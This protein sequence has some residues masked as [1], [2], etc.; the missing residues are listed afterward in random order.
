MAA[1]AGTI[2]VKAQLDTGQLQSG[3]KELQK[4]AQQASAAAGE[5]IENNITKS[6]N[7]VKTASKNL[8]DAVS[9]HINKI[10]DKIDDK[11][12]DVAKKSAALVG[13]AIS[14]IVG[15]AVKCFS[16]YEQLAGGVDK[17]FG[18]ASASVKKNAQDAFQ[19]AG[20]SANQYMDTVTNF[21]ASLISGLGGDTAKAAK[22][23]DVAIR[24]MAD[25]ANTFGTSM[26]EIEY[27]YKGFSKQNYTMLDNLKLG[28]GGTAAEMARLVNDSGVMG[29]KFK[30][31]AKNINKVSFDKLIEAVHVIQTRMKIAGTTSREAAGTLEGSFN[32]MKAAA[33]NF[34][35]ALGNGKDVDGA[36]QKMV[37]SAQTWLG[38]LMPV[39]KRV[40]DSII[41]ML[42]EKFPQF[43]KPARQVVDFVIK[44]KD[45][46][47]NAFIAIGGA[48]AAIRIAKFAADLASAIG[49]FAS[50]TKAAFGFVGALTKATFGFIGAVIRLGVALACNPIGATIAVIVGIIAA[51]TALYLKCEGFR[52]FVNGAVK[53]IIS[54][55]SG[56][57]TQIVGIF[58]SIV[59]FLKPPFDTI[60]A[61][62][63]ATISGIIT[64]V[65]PIVGFIVTMVQGII[66]TVTPIIQ[67]AI[68]IVGS[69]IEAI[70]A[71]L[72]PIVVIVGGI[73]MTVIGVLAPIVGFIAQLIGQIIQF[74]APTIKFVTDVVAAIFNVLTPIAD[75]IFKNVLAPMAQFIHDVVTPIV[76]FISGVIQT[77]MGVITPVI[78]FV[79]GLVQGIINTIGPIINTIVQIVIGVIAIVTATITPIVGFIAG[80]VGKIFGIIG[81]IAGWIWKN[82]LSPVVGFYT[83]VIG[84]IIG[85]VVGLVGKIF[86]TLGAIAGWVWSHVI[87][88][89]AGFFKGLWDG[90]CSGIS[91]AAKIISDVFGTIVGI[92]KAPINCIIDL[93]NG[94][95]GGINSIKIPDWVPGLGG[96]SA[97]IPKIPRLARGGFVAGAGT[98]TSDSIP[99]MLSNGEY[100][101]NAR[102]VDLIGRDTLDNLNAGKTEPAYRGGGS[103]TVN[104]FFQ[105][106]RQSNSRWQYEQITRRAL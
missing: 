78:S 37:D 47:I 97:N 5:A 18:N 80:V 49:T 102:A 9:K 88:P 17:L 54:F 103:S 11:V 53:A 7:N 84:G 45:L 57:A 50:I 30:A 33:Q 41:K 104:N 75:W 38:N 2:T 8:K 51:V 44:N 63:S 55:F 65:G 79:V 16:D 64:M 90:I 25:N 42:D 60:V 14:T 28:Y 22:V 89:V 58:N 19:T 94:V 93:I 70:K 86:G 77:I 74:I 36:F 96:M 76:S 3:F 24:D 12:K 39:V 72:T 6:F 81:A 56:A 98:A 73:V 26:S 43:M 82:V 101:I 31:T 100:V 48:L 35:T 106:D 91:G 95:I 46:I 23:A 32:S 40:V 105:F 20:M 61:I 68:S 27:A 4:T 29:S 92:V 13:G 10:S 15:G 21:S 66:N 69:V 34:L 52:N 99:A 62:V 87:Q 83:K 1:D 59:K 85:A 67:T 71:V